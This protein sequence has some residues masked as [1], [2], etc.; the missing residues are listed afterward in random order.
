MRVELDLLENDKQ[1]TDMILNQIK[2]YI[3]NAINKSLTKIADEL[4]T[5]V[6]SALRNQPEY[7]SL[8][9]G[10]LKAEFGL[11]DSSSINSIIIALVNTLQIS[12]Q[13][14]Q[15]KSSGLSGGLTLTMMK[16]DDMNGIIY[17]SIAGVSSGEQFL[18]WLEWLLFSGN[19]EIVKG[20]DIKYGNYS[21]SR[22]G[23]AIMDISSNG[24][25]VPKQF[26][27]NINDNWTTRAIDSVETDI[28]RII[29]TN[30]ESQL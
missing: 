7:A 13:N 19:T 22:S 23:M 18:P 5:L 12:K 29:K 1:I 16:S 28:Y 27:G 8:M 20:Y 25:S 11:S 2:T 26:S 6:A 15:I 10:T 24:W 14:I 17:S 9:S 21:R 3:E 4:K 30:I